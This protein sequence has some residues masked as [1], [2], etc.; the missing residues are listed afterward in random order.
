VDARGT[1]PLTQE[2]D[3]LR[4]HAQFDRKKNWI[5][6]ADS[7]NATFLGAL[8][9]AKQCRERFINHANTAADRPFTKDWTDEA[10]DSLFL[11]YL[12]HG[13]KWTLIAHHMQNKYSASDPGPRTW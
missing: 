3:F 6:I 10:L 12:E 13:H 4:Q 9:S 5:R 1:C 11:L 7:F 2:D 8:R